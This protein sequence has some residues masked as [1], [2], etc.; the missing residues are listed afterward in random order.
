MQP[1]PANVTP[2]PDVSSDRLST[3][4][5]VEPGV[6]CSARAVLEGTEQQL[7]G[8]ERKC[9]RVTI[10]DL[11][12]RLAARRRRTTWDDEGDLPQCSSEE[13][14]GWLTGKMVCSS[15]TGEDSL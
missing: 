12:L 14:K 2:D 8:S 1:V 3:I 10:G 11:V 13:E 6:G 15:R 7:D 9:Q 4:F 5:H